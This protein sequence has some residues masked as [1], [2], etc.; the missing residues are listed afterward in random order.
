MW[1]PMSIWYDT[2]KAVW[3]DI[4]RSRPIASFSP[5]TKCLLAGACAMKCC[6]HFSRGQITHDAFFL[7]P[8]AASR[9]AKM[10]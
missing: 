9:D 2:A 5:R 7:V 6:M 1:F 10:I 8:A 3:Q 4:G